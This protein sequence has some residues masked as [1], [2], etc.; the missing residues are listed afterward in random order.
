M[1]S[2]PPGAAGPADQ[3]ARYE[4][5]ARGVLDGHWSG[6]FEGLQVSSDAPD[7]T[8]IAGPVAGQAA[9]NGRS[10]RSAT[11]ACRAVSA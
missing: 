4:I 8:L 3:A 1:L 6:W 10:P 5:R 11:S 9:L 7:Q 2:R